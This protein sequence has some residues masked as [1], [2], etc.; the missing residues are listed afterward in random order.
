MAAAIANAET[1]GWP[2]VIA[3][4]DNGGWL[5]AFFRMDNA[6][7]G[8]V[9]VAQGKARTAALFKRP[10]KAFDSLI[11]QGGR[12]VRTVTMPHVT[13]LEGGI[14]L[15]CNG[16]IIGAIGVSGMASEQDQVVAEAGAA[17]LL[18]A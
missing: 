14:P 17:A 4:V 5:Q 13:A 11:E 16:Q 15:Y 1:N 7:V 2:M 18:T 12:G 6:Q 8:S 3:I 10:T 9:D